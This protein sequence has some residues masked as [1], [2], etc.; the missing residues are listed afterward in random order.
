LMHRN[1][2][3]LSSTPELLSVSSKY[4]HGITLKVPHNLP[5]VYL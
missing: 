2:E 4:L 1:R 3:R 5:Q